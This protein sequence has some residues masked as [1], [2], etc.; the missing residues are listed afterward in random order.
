MG[1][2]R[3]QPI[4]I[5]GAIVPVGLPPDLVFKSKLINLCSGNVRVPYF[6]IAW[7]R[8]NITARE[9]SPVCKACMPPD[10]NN[11]GKRYILYD[12]RPQKYS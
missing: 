2:L 10:S 3:I 1:G 7:Y 11:L 12:L 5:P 4:V 9:K 8:A 6:V